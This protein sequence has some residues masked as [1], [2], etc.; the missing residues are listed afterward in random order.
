M[1]GGG[2]DP[3]TDYHG[4]VVATLRSR[5]ES[6]LT[7]GGPTYQI[8]ADTT[9]STSNQLGGVAMECTGE[10]TEIINNP[11][12]VFGISAKTDAGIVS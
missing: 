7:T 11:F 3:Y 1:N 2:I 9:D 4:M 8:S 6:T 5:G 12:N 10:Y